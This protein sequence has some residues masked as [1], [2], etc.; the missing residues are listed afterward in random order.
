MSVRPIDMLMVPQMNEVSHIKQSE[1]SK[2][3]VEQTNIFNQNQKEIEVKS[4]QVNT[5]DN[6]DYKD[7]KYDAKEKSNNEYYGKNLK[8]KAGNDDGS[9]VVKKKNMNFD[10]KV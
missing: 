9:V 10:M 7:Q 6:V 2:P 8:N 4:E 1:N 3:L 5:K